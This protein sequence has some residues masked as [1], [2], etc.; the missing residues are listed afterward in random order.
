MQDRGIN[1]SGSGLDRHGIHSVSEVYWTLG[2]AALVEGALRRG[3]ALLANN[4]AFDRQRRPVHRVLAAGQVHRAGAPLRGQDLVAAHRPAPRG[5]SLRP[6]LPSLPGLPRRGR[7]FVQ[8][9]FAGAHLRDHLPIRIIT[10]YPSDNLFARQLFVRDDPAQAHE[11]IPRF[12]VIDVPKFHA[13]PEGGGM[14]CESFLA[15]RL[16]CGL[17]TSGGTGYAGDWEGKIAT[18]S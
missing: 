2:T 15:V 1:A 10:E 11:R 17:I 7:V 16:R 13:L 8:D 14:R 6:P 9:C 5:S 12:T 18:S 3:G 4:G